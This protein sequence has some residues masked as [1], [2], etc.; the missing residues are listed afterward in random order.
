ME[1]DYLVTNLHEIAQAQAKQFPLAALRCA[2][3]PAPTQGIWHHNASLCYLIVSCESDL[4]TD[5]GSGYLAL[6]EGQA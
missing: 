4:I 5:G 1:V 6:F 3:G 2:A